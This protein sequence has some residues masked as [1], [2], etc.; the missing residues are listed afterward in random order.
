M[1]TET[2]GT[3]ELVGVY[4]PGSHHM[5]GDGFPVRNMIPGAGVDEQLSP[6]L[7]LDYMGPDQVPP[8]ARQRGVGEHP[9]RGFETVTIMYHGKVAHRDSTGS[10]GVIG[11]GDVQWMTAASG[12]VHEELHEKEFARQGGLLEGIQLWV[13]LPKAFK[14]TT[15]RYQTLVKEDIPSVDL[16]G[17][18][19]RLRVIAGTFRGVNGPARTFSPVHLYDV[20]LTAGHQ[21]E[22]ALPDGFNSSVFV[23]HGQVVVNGTQAVGDVEL[24]LLGKRGERVTLEAKQ[25]STLLVMSGQPI[26]EPIARYGPF[27]MNTREEIIQAVHDYQAGKMGHL[28]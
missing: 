16:G 27:V 11:P 1:H 28:S 3:K 7:M 2:I 22:L 6:F 14:M 13:N 26:E 23:L 25:D 17:G 10:G 20:R 15:P 12:V 9:H 24:A 19:G 8:S 4:Q 21:V 18:A 5:V